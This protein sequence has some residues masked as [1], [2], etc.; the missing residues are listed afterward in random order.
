LPFL[1][2]LFIVFKLFPEWNKT[3]Q[4]LP[5]RVKMCWLK[6]HQ[7]IGDLHWF[8][9][10]SVVL[11]IHST[12]LGTIFLCNFCLLCNLQLLMIINVV[13]FQ[14]WH[15]HIDCKWFCEMWV[16]RSRW[17]LWVEKHRRPLPPS[18]PN[19]L[20]GKASQRSFITLENSQVH[21]YTY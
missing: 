20:Q 2:H 3:N 13:F 17:K 6:I 4:R 21:S 14:S 5:W 18:N 15:E 16:V 11:Y 10:L 19:S 7:K 1:I 9:F 12:F 8:H